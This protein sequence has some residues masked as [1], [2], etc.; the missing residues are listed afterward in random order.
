[1]AG[2]YQIDLDECGKDPEIYVYLDDCLCSGNTVFYDL[3]GWMEGAKE[4]TTLYI[5]SIGLHRSAVRRCSPLIRALVQ[6]KKITTQFLRAHPY[7]NVSWESS[8]AECY[9]PRQIGDSPEID[10]YVASI[11]QRCAGKSFHP[12]LFRP[13]GMPPKEIIF[14]SAEARDG[15]EGAL[16]KAGVHIVG[17]PQ[18]PKLQMRPMGYEYL[19]SLGFGNLMVTYRNISNNSPL[20]LW[21]GDPNG[22]YPLNQWLPLFPRKPNDPAVREVEIEA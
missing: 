4:G 5:I 14:S 9:W 22:I 7:E 13:A 10:A 8:A 18:N 11:N 16:L 15:I 20:A 17:L 1:L 12:R 6:Q 3:K 2:T 21:W 19:E